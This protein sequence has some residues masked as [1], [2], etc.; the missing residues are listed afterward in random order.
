[1]RFAAVAF[2]VFHHPIGRYIMH[3]RVPSGLPFLFHVLFYFAFYLI[4]SMNALNWEVRDLNI[5]FYN[6][7]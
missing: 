3:L 5:L 7:P 2:W 1:M 6:F 4:L